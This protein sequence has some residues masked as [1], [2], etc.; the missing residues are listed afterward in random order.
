MSTHNL[1]FK[2]KIRKKIYLC[3]PQFHYIKVGCKG[4][5]ITWT[6]LHDVSK[7]TGESV[8]CSTFPFLMFFRLC[9]R[10]AKVLGDKYLSVS[11]FSNRSIDGFISWSR[12]YKTFFMLNW[13]VHEVYPAHNCWHFNIYEQD[14]WLAFMI[15]LFAYHISFSRR[16]KVRIWWHLM[17]IQR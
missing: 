13:T 7:L 1:C 5:F 11:I 14:K 9:K 2:A 12:G 8:S 3:T 4:V 15:L 17:I 16:N 6:C 10:W